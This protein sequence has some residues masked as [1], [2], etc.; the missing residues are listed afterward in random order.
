MSE[1]SEGKGDAPH[2][3]LF[4]AFEP[5]GDAHAAPVIRALRHMVPELKVYAWG[6]PLMKQ[7]G[8]TIVEET[9]GDGAMGLNAFRRIAAT[10]RQIG[11]IRRWARAYRVLAHVAV[12]SPAANFPICKEMRATGARVV[13]LVAPQLWAWGRW[14]VRKLRRLTDLVLCLLPFEEQWFTQRGIPARFIGHP[15]MNRRLD[16]KDLRERMHGLPQGAPRIALFPGSRSHEVRANI[17]LL[18]DA[19]NELQGRNSGMAGVIVA[20]NIPLARLVRRKIRVFPTGLHLTSGQV[21]A[22]IGWSDLCLAVSGTIALDIARQQKPMIG[23][24]KTNPLAWLLSLFILRTRLRLLPNIIAEREIVPEFVP[25]IGGA[26]PI[27]KQAARFLQ[28]S[29][30]AAIQ[31]E[32]LARV[33]SRFANKNPPDE[34]ARLI[35]KIIR[36][37]SVD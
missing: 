26:G 9:A 30:N 33:C 16:A 35:L 29:K 13:H 28:D 8:A 27:V 18:V 21:D 14:R 32:E 37:G 22:A 4:T 11:R 3:V 15:R 36:D 7:A 34:A 6:G 19:F 23:V 10:R 12:D 25:H 31:A 24:Y 1:G 5:S 20:A 2:S 17:R